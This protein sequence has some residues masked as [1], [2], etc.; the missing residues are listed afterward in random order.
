MKLDDALR[1]VSRLGLDTAPFIYLVERH[2]DYGE[3]CLEVVQRMATG[4]MAGA[5]STIT[6]GEV[7]VQPI[8]RGD[9]LL[10]RRFTN[11]LLHGIGFR[12]YPVDATSA[13]LA[14]NLRAAYGLHLADACQLA[15]AMRQQCEAFLTNDRRLARV[16]ETRVLVL[17]DL[18]L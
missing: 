2:P 17:D 12:M 5:T 13:T 4:R 8:R 11:V 18:E 1:G 6:L 7:L 3:I 15:V 9:V 16:T 10:Q 14:A